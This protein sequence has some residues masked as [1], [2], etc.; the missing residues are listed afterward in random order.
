[1]RTL[2]SVYSGG[3]RRRVY[4]ISRLM[5]NPNFLILDEPTNDLDIPTMENLEEYIASFPGCCLIVSHDRAFLN[6]ICTS[7]FVIQDRER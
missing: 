3:E 1:M 6:C 4:L 7:L 2:M 5:E